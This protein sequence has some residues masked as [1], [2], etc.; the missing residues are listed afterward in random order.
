MV[1]YAR[2]EQ[3]LSG[4]GLEH[5]PVAVA[6]LSTAPPNVERFEGISARPAG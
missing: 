4:I 5:R 2:I 3:Q 6:F 1:D